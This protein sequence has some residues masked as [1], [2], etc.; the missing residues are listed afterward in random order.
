MALD[1][2][3]KVFFDQESSIKYTHKTFNSDL[4][5]RSKIDEFNLNQDTLQVA[6]A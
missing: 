6:L 3:E 1:N 5:E 2:L 4:S